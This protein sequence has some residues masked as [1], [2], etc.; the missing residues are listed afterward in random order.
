[1]Y[2]PGDVLRWGQQVRFRHMTTGLYLCINNQQKICLREK[3]KD[4]LTVFR[5]HS[6]TKVFTTVTDPLIPKLNKV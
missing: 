5:L 2:V 4:P 6:I 1:M 3:C